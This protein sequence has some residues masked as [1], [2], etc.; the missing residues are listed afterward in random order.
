MA[1]GQ[2]T[3][4]VEIRELTEAEKMHIDVAKC[5]YAICR[6]SIDHDYAVREIIGLDAYK[7]VKELADVRFRPY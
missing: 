4:K 6:K 7:K 2:L 1:F 5:I 3:G